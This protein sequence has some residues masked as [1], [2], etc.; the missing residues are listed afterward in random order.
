M[1]G[2]IAIRQINSK[3]LTAVA[4][5]IIITAIMFYY[6]AAIFVFRRD[7]LVSIRR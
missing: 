2:I 3:W 1:I 4:I 6:E 5:L 7:V